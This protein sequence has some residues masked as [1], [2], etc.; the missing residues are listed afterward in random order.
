MID[1]LAALLPITEV[2]RATL[3]RW[4]ER[5]IG[6]FRVLSVREPFL[7]VVNVLNEQT[8]YGQSRRERPSIPAI[9][10]DVRRPRPVG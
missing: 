1:I 10:V 8:L 5:H 2:Q 4:Y 3:R 6:Y 9:S 7:D